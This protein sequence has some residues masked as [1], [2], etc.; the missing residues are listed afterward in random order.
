MNWDQIVGQW[1]QRR[2]KAVH[3]WGKVMNDELAGVAGKYEELAGKLQKKYG[4]AKEEA[5]R[6]VNEFKKMVEQLKKTRKS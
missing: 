3:H 2:E 1:K 5:K 4:I 6:Q